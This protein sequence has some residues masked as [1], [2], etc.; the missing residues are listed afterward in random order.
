MSNRRNTTGND[1]P[2]FRQQLIFSN[3]QNNFKSINIL[4]ASFSGLTSRL[5]K[6]QESDYSC[7]RGWR[8]SASLS[9]IYAPPCNSPNITTL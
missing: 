3:Y 6:L 8:L 1:P 4:K 2:T 7:P 5:E 9:P